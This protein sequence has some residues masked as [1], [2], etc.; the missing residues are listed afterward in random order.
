MHEAE[1]WQSCVPLIH[2]SISAGMEKKPEMSAMNWR[3]NVMVA[4]DLRL[5]FHF[6][7]LLLDM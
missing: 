3:E 4:S 5:A 6:L 1:P 2:S 7:T